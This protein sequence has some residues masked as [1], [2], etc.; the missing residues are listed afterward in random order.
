MPMPKN[1]VTVPV[2]PEPL[3]VSPGIVAVRT[4]RPTIRAVVR[5]PA[6]AST[7]KL[8]WVPM[9]DWAWLGMPSN[10]SRPNIPVYPTPISIP[11]P[12]W[13]PLK[14]LA[15]RPFPFVPDVPM[16]K[17]V[18]RRPPPMSCP[19]PTRDLELIP[20]NMCAMSFTAWASTI[21]RLWLYWAPTPWDDATLT[22]VDS[23]DLGQMPRLPSPTNTFACCW[24]NVGLPKCLTMASRGLDR[25]NT[26]IPLDNS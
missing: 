20:P 26:K 14:K 1:A 19:M 4:R 25:I 12:V 22:A 15:A 11:M 18:P 16:P 9:P 23:G 13:W 7:P 10:P 17:M 6:C 3:F 5:V 8:P 2:W 21:R 24:K